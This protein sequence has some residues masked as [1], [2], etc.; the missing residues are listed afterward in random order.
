[1]F[2][3]IGRQFRRIRLQ[4]DRLLNIGHIPK[5]ESYLCC[6]IVNTQFT[7]GPLA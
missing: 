5:V 2:H 3:V 1:M 6:Q 7:S 4:S